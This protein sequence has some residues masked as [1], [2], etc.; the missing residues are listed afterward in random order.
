MLSKMMMEGG[1]VLVLDDP[2]NHLDLESITALDN[3]LREF[4]GTLLF[5]S[6]DL[7]VIQSVANRIIELTPTG[8]IDRRMSYEEYLADENIKTQRQ[9]MYQLV[10]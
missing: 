5:A 4:N 9:R 7:Q 10:S 2:T 3:S 6:H 8:I 1:N